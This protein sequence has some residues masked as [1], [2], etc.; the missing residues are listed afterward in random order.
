MRLF[1]KGG[2]NKTY[3]PDSKFKG[4][5]SLVNVLEVKVGRGP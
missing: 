1:V 4:L 2:K 5:A 3:T